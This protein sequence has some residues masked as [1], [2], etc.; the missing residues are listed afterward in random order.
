VDWLMIL[1]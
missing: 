1:H